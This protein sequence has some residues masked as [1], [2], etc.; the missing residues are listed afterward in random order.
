[1]RDDANLDYLE[2]V[3][4]ESSNFDSRIMQSAYS[5]ITG[6][7]SNLIMWQLE[8]DNILERIDHLV[9][10]DVLEE[11]GEGNVIYVKATDKDLV[12][13]NEYGAQL[14]MNF[15][16]PYLNRNT[17]LSNYKQDR[18]YE[19]L[20]D[21]GIELAD[22]IYVNYEKMGLNTVEKKSRSTV[23]CI[24]ILHM[25]ESSYNRSIMGA[26][27]ESLRTAR[28]VTQNQPLNPPGME[29]MQMQHPKRGWSLNPFKGFRA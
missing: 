27:R 29:H 23:I 17:I 15:I 7:Q 4:N 5:S 22:L 3:Q 25:I 28:I 8:L 2:K 16:S 9:R 10:G 14:I 13:F 26:E 19:I 20:D 6:D 11:V 21:L 1:M 24:N 12:V 18:I